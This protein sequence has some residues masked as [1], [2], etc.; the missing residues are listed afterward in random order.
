MIWKTTRL[1]KKEERKV[2]VAVFHKFIQ[3]Q[4][5]YKTKIQKNFLHSTSKEPLKKVMEK[6]EKN[7]DR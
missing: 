2:K 1:N 3:N 6:E 7:Q 5:N 4:P